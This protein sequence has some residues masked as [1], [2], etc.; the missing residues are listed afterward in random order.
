MRLGLAE[1]ITNSVKDAT[2]QVHGAEGIP[3]NEQMK[4]ITQKTI[5]YFLTGAKFMFFQKSLLIAGNL[6]RIAEVEFYRTPDPFIHGDIDQQMSS[7]CFYFHKNGGTYKN[8]TFKGLDI[9]MGDGQVYASMLI[10]SIMTPDGFIEGPCNVVDYI[11]KKNNKTKIEDLITAIS[12][13]SL[14]ISTYFQNNFLMLIPANHTEMKVYNGPRVGLSLKKEKE[15]FGLRSHYVMKEFRFTC[16]PKMIK[17]DRNMLAVA[18]RFKGIPDNVI[19]EDF[20]LQP[21]LLGKW[22]TQFIKGKS[23][24][25]EYFLTEDNRKLDKAN[26]QL[27]AYGFFSQLDQ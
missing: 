25:I 20:A 17:K 6:C 11:L 23:L 8:G 13:P 16:F 10:R 22:V 21:S 14:P 12:P 26:I 19:I 2:L 9:T 18:A 24:Y 15:I 4:S 5:E 3:L 7:N 27:Q 1:Q